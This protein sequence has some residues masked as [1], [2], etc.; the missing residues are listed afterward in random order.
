VHTAST[1]E[2]ITD[3][4]AEVEGLRSTHPPTDDEMILAK[5]SLTRGYPRSF[6]T[7]QQVARAVAQLALYRLPDSYFEDFAPRVVAITAEDVT[8]A[9][10]THL[11]PARLTTLVVGDH[12]AIDQSL[13]VL[14]LGPVEVEG[15]FV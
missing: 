2:A 14:G 11:D 10:V 7:A 15:G 9:A 4:L 8:R 5:A 1:A 3:A 6:E 13:R 12:T